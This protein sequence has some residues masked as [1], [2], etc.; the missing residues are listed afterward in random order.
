LAAMHAPVPDPEFDPPRTRCPLC[1]SDRLRHFD[2][3]YRGITIDRCADCGVRFMNPVYTDGYLGRFYATYVTDLDV[4]PERLLIRRAQKLGKLELIERHAP[5]GR[6]LSV[7]CGDALELVLARERGWHVEGQDIDPETTARVASESGIRLHC[8]DLLALRLPTGSWDAIL[9]DQVLEHPKNP[10]AYLRE[11]R[12]LLAPGGIAC[13]AVPN[14]GSLAARLKTLQGKAHLKRA[15]GKHYDSWHHLT[16][17]TPHS[18]RRAL[19][20]RHGFEVLTLR[21]D[22][23]PARSR[24]ARVAAAARRRFPLLDSSMVLVARPIGSGAAG[25]ASDV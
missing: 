15:R 25:S 12:R 3:D 10:G 5:V 6:L 9:L 13:I 8:G 17:Y 23:R 2:R 7:G 22:P 24:V 19:E 16:Y 11:V 4:L 20:R 18:L 21:G 1:D 14:T